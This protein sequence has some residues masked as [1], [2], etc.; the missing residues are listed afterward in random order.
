NLKKE[1]KLME[2]ILEVNNLTK[3]YK[4]KTVVNNLNLKI[5][6]GEIYGLLGQNGA[7]KTT[8]MCMIT[9][10]SHK[11]EG[12]IKLFGQDTTNNNQIF[13]KVGSIIE[14]PGFYENLTGYENLKYFAKIQKITNKKDIDI[15]LKIME[16]EENKNK[17]VKE[18]SMGMK[19][20]LAIAEAIMNKPELLILDEPIN[21]LDPR[22]I[23]DI[24]KFLK[25]LSKEQNMT[26]IISSHILSEIEQLVDR[27]GIINNGKLIEEIT[28]DNLH[29]KMNKCL[30]FKVSDTKKSSK[31]LKEKFNIACKIKENKIQIKDFNNTATINKE[32]VKNEISV[33]QIETIHENLEDYFLKKIYQENLEEVYTN[34]QEVEVSA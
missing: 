4:N 17:K 15:A 25:K 23:L 12:E 19:Q 33:S 26:I 28:M 10:L 8:T 14:S 16:L 31:I 21:G 5:K 6:K 1:V 11:T 18:Y 22:G 24:R 13:Q 20:R 2:Y 27:I 9:N 3:K 30:E 29:E 7:G 34:D 32:F